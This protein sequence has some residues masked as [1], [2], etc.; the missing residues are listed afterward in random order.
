MFINIEIDYRQRQVVFF[1]ASLRLTS[2]PKMNG[3]S[4]GFND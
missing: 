2:L 1:Y 3:L 4:M